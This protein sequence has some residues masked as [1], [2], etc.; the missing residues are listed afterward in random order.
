MW[1]FFVE[2]TESYCGEIVPTFGADLVFYLERVVKLS[3]GYS[4]ILK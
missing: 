4:K 3:R 2:L 1:I